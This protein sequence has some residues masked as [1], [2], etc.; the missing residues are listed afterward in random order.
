M[1]YF[2][3]SKSSNGSGDIEYIGYIIDIASSKEGIECPDPSIVHS[4]CEG[5]D[6]KL[7]V[8]VYEEY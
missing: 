4:F 3:I 5:Q 2:V 8:K 7:W 1:M 6:Y